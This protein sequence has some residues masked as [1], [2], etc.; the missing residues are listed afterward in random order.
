MYITKGNYGSIHVCVHSRLLSNGMD[1]AKVEFSQKN[2]PPTL[3]SN[4]A[5]AIRN[6]HSEKLKLGAD[7]TAQ[8]DISRDSKEDRNVG[9]K[10]GF[11]TKKSQKLDSEQNLNV[12][13]TGLSG[14]KTGNY[15]FSS[16]ATRGPLLQGNKPTSPNALIK[17]ASKCSVDQKH[18]AKRKADSISR[19]EN[20]EALRR[21]DTGGHWKS[22]LNQDLQKKGPESIMQEMNAILLSYGLEVSRKKQKCNDKK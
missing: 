7:F 9:E 14:V 1:T 5:V 15:V 21:E 11:P 6:D 17:D 16:G 4:E 8:H 13:W 10:K 12:R 20:V 3:D 22:A 2:V 19:N 18:G